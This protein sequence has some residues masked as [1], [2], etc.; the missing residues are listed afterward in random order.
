MFRQ[1]LTI[2]ILCLFLVTISASFLYA[3]RYADRS[4]LSGEI[5]EYIRNKDK[6]VFET[7]AKRYL[8]KPSVTLETFLKDRWVWKRLGEDPKNGTSIIRKESGK[9]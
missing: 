3:Q 8:E 7:N 2:S 9:I 1:N 4:I 6:D 5:E